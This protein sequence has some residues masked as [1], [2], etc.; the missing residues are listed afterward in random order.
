MI[1]QSLSIN[2]SHDSSSKDRTSDQPTATV[3]AGLADRNANLFRRIGLPL[4]DPT[5]WIELPSGETIRIVRDLE[6]GRV[7]EAADKAAAELPASTPPHR[8]ACPADFQPPSGLSGDRETAVAQSVAACLIEHKVKRVRA[9]RSLPLIYAWHLAEAGIPIDYDD[10]LGVR[11]RRVKTQAELEAMAHAQH[12]TEQVMFEVCHRIATASVD[13][14]GHLFQDD[15]LM[16]SE[17][18]VNYAMRGFMERGFTMSHGA[19]VAAAP[20]SA[21]CHHSGTGPLSTGVPIIV[22]LYP[23]DELTRYNGDCTRTVVHGTPSEEVVRMHAAVVAAKAAAEAQL[24]PGRTAESVHLAS[25]GELMKAGYPYSRGEFT[26]EPSIQHG[27]GHGIGLEV[28][29]PILLDHGGEAMLEGEVFTVEP[30]L[31][32]RRLGGVRIEDM[33][34]VTKDGPKNF[35][36]LQYGLN[37]E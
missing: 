1:H 2:G 20:Y 6:M 19:I 34:L 21:D 15:E 11:D 16:T 30:G 33:L 23:R 35:N 9:D 32:G 5:A 8:V 25:D 3:F 18:V 28:H 17:R 24:F 12:V 37:W 22:D 13:D 26:D 36:Q 29:E 31:Y 10:E 27:T 4:G 14:D 7:I